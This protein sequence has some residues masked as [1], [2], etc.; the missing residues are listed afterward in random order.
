MR[1]SSF[2]SLALLWAAA[3]GGWAQTQSVS[4]VSRS[5]DAANKK[6]VAKDSTAEATNIN[7]I[8]LPQYASGSVGVG[9]K[10]LYVS[11]EAD[12]A[13]C[14]LHVNGQTT[15]I[16]CD[17]A[18]LKLHHLLVEGDGSTLHIYG[19]TEDTGRLTVNA[20]RT[21]TAVDASGNRWN[22]GIG[23]IGTTA[24]ANLCFHGGT[25]ETYGCGESPAIGGES[26]RP[27][28]AIAF[29]GGSVK[30]DC[31]DNGS[32]GIGY[33]FSDIN[34][35]DG[36]VKAYGNERYAGISG[37]YANGLLVVSI[38]DGNIEAWGGYKAAG[39]GGDADGESG[40]I[41]ISGG[42]VRAYGGGY[43]AGIGGGINGHGCL[44]G[45][46]EGH[47]TY[48]IVISGGTVF[49]WGHI[50]AAGIGG[51]EDGDSGN[52]LISG[53]TVRARGVSNGSG[54][55]AGEDGKVNI[56]AITGGTVDASGGS[57]DGFAIGTNLSDDAAK[58]TLI[59]AD[60]MKVDAGSDGSEENLCERRFT[61]NERVPACW[62]RKF[63]KIA[64]CHHDT[65]QYGSDR[66]EAISYTIGNNNTHTRYCRYCNVTET[67][68]HQY[69]AE[70]V[71]ECGH[72]FDA[73]AD[74]WTVTLYQADPYAINVNHGNTYDGGTVY[75]LSKAKSFSLP[76]LRTIEGV[77]IMALV[78]DP[79]S[80]PTTIWLTDDEMEA[81]ADFLD[82]SQP[83][84]FTT[85]NTVIYVRYRLDFTTEW[86]WGTD[87][88]GNI[89]LN[90]V[91]INMKCPALY[92]QEILCR[93][94]S[95]TVNEEE[96]D[97]AYTATVT[98][99]YDNVTY[100]FTDVKHVHLYDPAIDVRDDTSN[101]SIINEYKGRKADVTLRG[102]TF[103]KNGTWDAIFLPFALSAEQLADAAC[104]LHDAT[105]KQLV[106]S[107]FADGTLTLTF[108]DAT[109]IEAGTPYLVK[110]P[111]G[112]DVADPVFK[113]VTVSNRHGYSY[114]SNIVF[115]GSYNPYKVSPGTIATRTILCVGDDNTLYCPSAAMTI[116]PCRGYFVLFGLTAGDAIGDVNGDD[117]VT[118]ADVTA[119]VN[120][121][122]G[123]AEGN[124]LADVN[125]DE[126]VTIA[127]VTNL[128]NIILGKT[129]TPFCAKT[130]TTNVEGLGM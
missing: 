107:T 128:V 30:A 78:K 59:L 2:I 62:Y 10:T 33:R 87:A 108:R 68:E 16:L 85:S 26:T 7:D 105:I 102:R 106:G 47:E 29:F 54:I 72:V 13:N 97:I 122:L 41:T 69:N 1:M 48:G 104:P 84:S 126:K 19:Q 51:G 88:D 24:D 63:A 27:G 110:W 25:I 70:Q 125:C 103:V 9:N 43:A 109:A 89:D 80:T 127:D 65:P 20:Q 75:R 8:I 86:R 76:E 56:I 121:I 49:A 92:E 37:S 55:G 5:W 101:S 123:Q 91:Y 31:R 113:N 94:I 115:Q 129:P 38:Y 114:T 45:N 60:S 4:F 15:L 118:I 71:C 44:G 35:Y 116:K 57:D 11:G 50:D 96:N 22:V 90:D 130:I 100:T 79:A 32:C 42:T 23:T 67:V 93:D 14:D 74:E 111:T 119:L 3:A 112:T 21:P 83:L 117:K 64:V 61:N 6:V 36:T 77:K 18:N 66:T 28:A 82:P 99:P 53:G 81:E 17:D 58:G 95:T 98:Y 34:I 73:E 39:I 12:F 124:P 46:V 40:F 52:I 120:I